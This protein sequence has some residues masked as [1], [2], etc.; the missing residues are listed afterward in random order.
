[1]SSLF[2]LLSFVVVNGAVIKL[3]RERPD[4][5]RPYEIPYYPI[6]PIL[7]IVLNLVLT[8]V[9]IVYLVRTDPVALALSAAW[10][11]L[12]VGAYFGLNRMKAKQ[13]GSGA[14]PTPEAEPAEDD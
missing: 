13:T 14:E 8:I 11:V 4:M 5:N 7:G 3:R 9:L 1:M 12:G 2:F 6:P 10:M